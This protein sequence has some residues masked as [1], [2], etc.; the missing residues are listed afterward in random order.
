MHDAP[1]RVLRVIL[2]V[3]VLLT[4]PSANAQ[5]R[6]PPATITNVRLG[7]D[8][9]LPAERWS[10]VWIDVRGGPTAFEGTLT[11]SYVQDGTQGAEIVLPI[12]T[13][14]GQTVPF[15]LAICPPRNL[16]VVKL[17]LRGRGYSREYDIRSG[18]AADT[19]TLPMVQSEGLLALIVGECSASDAFSAEGRQDT[20]VNVVRGLWDEIER[21][22]WTPQRLPLGWKAYESVDVVVGRAEALAEA[23]PRAR[24]ALMT[25]VE[26]GGRLVV[27]ADGPGDRWAEF[28]GPGV[29]ELV[30]PARVVPDRAM[31]RDMADSVAGRVVRVMPAGA[32][33]GWV[34]FWPLEGGEAHLAAFGPVGVGM[35]TVL[36][37]DPKRIPKVVDRAETRRLWRPVFDDPNFGAVASARRAVTEQDRAMY[38]A[39]A[40]GSDVRAMNAVR[41]GLDAI[42]SVTAVGDG[43]FIL[44]AGSVVLL[45][46]LIG[47]LD[48]FV[49]RRRGISR[50]SWATAL[51]WIAAASA[52]ALIAP[53]LVRTDESVAS[54]ARVVDMIDDGTRQGAW[55]TALSAVFSGSPLVTE[56]GGVEGSWW[57]GVSP[58]MYYGEPRG[59]GMGAVRT[60][61]RGGESRGLSI[62]PL[63][64]GQ[65]TLRTMLEQ[66]PGQGVDAGLPRVEVFESAGG[67]Q[68]LVRGMPEGAMVRDGGVRIGARGAGVEFRQAD[69]ARGAPV[70]TATVRHEQLTRTDDMIWRSGRAT[71]APDYDQFG[72]AGRPWPTAAFDLP[73]VQERADAVRARLAVEGW[74]AVVIEIVSLPDPGLP[75]V[76]RA[77]SHTALVL[78][79]C[80]RVQR[81]EETP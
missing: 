73:G 3:I 30:P 58:V 54:R 49:L 42:A 50:W 48:W 37:V 12:A 41:A 5:R 1:A 64:Q 65:W 72:N 55:T 11:L 15:E 25:W 35:V 79:A 34:T 21:V 46:G 61:V 67:Y 71:A 8:G 70:W 10:P 16:S 56:F 69:D 23:E 17:E 18:L 57:R 44:L 22:E 9:H 40:S 63:P 47:P 77:R 29:L 78:R 53:T 60:L 59:S 43:T 19:W 2:G 81:G 24:E 39:N 75:K 76:A 31:G 28:V 51:G 14:P 52:T 36:G 32:R 13:T 33:D 45:A 26:S 20:P 68:V 80:V 66:Q 6:E 62:A 7:W 4:V 27:L 38:W 74:A